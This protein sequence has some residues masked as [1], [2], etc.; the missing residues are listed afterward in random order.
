MDAYNVRKKRPVTG[1]QM[2]TV[3]NAVIA[4]VD[5]NGKHFEVL[6]DPDIAYALREGKTVSV[7]K[8]LAVND[9]FTDSK[10]GMKASPAALEEVFGTSDVEKISEGIV[11]K[12][13]IQLTTDFRRRKTEEKKK[14]IATAVSRIAMDPTTKMPHP[15]ERILNA[16]EQAHVDVDPFKSADDQVEDTIKALRD[17][18]PI[19][20][21]EV[22]LLVQVSP[23]HSGR[24][25]G[26]LKEFGI[27]HEE[28]RNDGSLVARVRIAAGLKENL[29]R[30]VNSAS[31]GSANIE[32]DK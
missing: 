24:V 26:I 22:V 20:T 12:G 11:R 31:D 17:V 15:P 18:L 6:V 30:R 10:K 2:V 1:D 4:R 16:M 32:E 14:Q 5:K 19:S 29:Y 3:D 8:M 25:Y 13:D 27:I 28:W 23:Q 21:D 9:V 7:S